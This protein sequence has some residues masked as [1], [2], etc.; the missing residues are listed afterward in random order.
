MWFKE[1][2][3][4]EVFDY[5][6]G[7]RAAFRKAVTKWKYGKQYYIIKSGNRQAMYD[8]LRRMRGK[9]TGVPPVYDLQSNLLK[10]NQAKVEA[11]NSCFAKSFQPCQLCETENMPSQDYQLM[12]ESKCDPE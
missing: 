1:T 3:V 6:R 7:L 5:Y 10:D 8:H 4:Q 2:I 11:F 9:E 12:D